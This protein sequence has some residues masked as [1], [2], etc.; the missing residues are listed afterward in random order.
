MPTA[1]GPGAVTYAV[2]YPNRHAVGMANLGLQTVAGL[3]AGLPGAL[4]HRSFA[5]CSGTLEAGRGLG[6]YH[7]VA[8]TLSFEGD[9]L[10]ALHQLSR[11]GIPLRSDQ[12]SARYPLV[13]VGGVAPTLNPEPLAPF[14]DVVFLG[15]AE[16]GLAAL[17]RF[18]SAHLHRPRPELLAA[19]ADAALPGV[20][21]PSRYRVTEGGA[22]IERE[23]LGDAPALVERVWATLPWSPAR[24]RILAADDAFGGAYLLE[25]GRGCPHACRFCATGYLTRPMRFLPLAAL[26]PWIEAGVAAAGRVGF[27]SAAVSNHPELEALF[28]ATLERGGG[29]TVS[30]FRAESLTPR[31]L[32][33]LQRGGLRT[34][35]VAL[36]AGTAELRRALGKNLDEEQLLHAAALAGEAGLDGLRI[37]AMVG[38]PGERD[39]D[40][41]ALAELG[42]RAR[43]ALG[44]GTVTLSV[45]PFVPKPHTP[46]QW[47]PMAAE[48]DLRRRIRLLQSLGRRERGVK[49]TAEAPKG[50]RVQG[51]LS[52][53][54]R[55]VAELLEGVARGGTWRRVLQGELARQV[56]D[57]PWDVGAPLP[58]GFVG[59]TP[60]PAYLRDQYEAGPVGGP[61]VPCRPG[62]C[63][64]C[65]VCPPVSGSGGRDS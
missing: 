42:A 20:Y 35:T 3:L 31:R 26:L 52:R 44:R 32:E 60:D 59:G 45:A 39:A 16:A 33:L 22:G 17:H 4:C 5:D 56:L 55:A 64:V 21:V 34:L 23:P 40:V 2:L 49:V 30:S 13:V 14:A 27:V 53:G 29:F 43:R 15:E 38:L 41:E 37:Y 19:L 63:R 9:Y 25:I 10:E 7:V 24:S 18:L 51:L 46:L 54:G 57:Q 36:E 8:L 48:S 12:R 65:G 61:L 47:A 28:E 50:A 6:E 11:N 1:G 62:S 58:W